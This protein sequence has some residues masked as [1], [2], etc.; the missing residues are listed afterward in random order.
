MYNPL[1]QVGSHCVF[2]AEGAVEVGGYVGVVV[3]LKI[4]MFGGV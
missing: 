4:M 2:K 1:R 3:D